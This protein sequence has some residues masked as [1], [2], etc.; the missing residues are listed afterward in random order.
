MYRLYEFISWVITLY[1][2]LLFAA[3][4]MS[5]LAA[6]NVVNQRNSVV[7]AVSEFL[8]RATEPALRPFRRFVP[9]VGG[10]D[11]SPIALILLL[12]FLRDVVVP[13]VL[14]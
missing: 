3:A 5:W 2:Y 6:F 10:V 8:W 4:V 13:A 7:A 1:I 9:L 14:L 12:V 11:I